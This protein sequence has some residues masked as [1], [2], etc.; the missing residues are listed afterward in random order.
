MNA[1]NPQ[2][3]LEAAHLEAF[4]TEYLE[5]QTRH[6]EVVDR[7]VARPGDP[8]VHELP[9][10]PQLPPPVTIQDAVDALRRVAH[11][12]QQIARVQADADALIAPLQAQIDQIRAWAQHQIT[13]RERRLGIHENRLVLYYRLNSPA[14]GKTLALPGGKI[15]CRA[16]QPEWRYEDERALVELLDA[17]GHP[18][19]RV[20]REV[21]KVKLKAMVEVRQDGT[22][23]DTS[24]GA[25]L[26]GVRVVERPPV[27]KVEVAG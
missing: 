23:V 21:D 9:P 27:Y 4:E 7:L 17:D 2:T 19:I 10:A 12:R 5:A 8:E 6:D 11:H 25:I 22:V 14:G 3:V 15:S 18:A 20:R 1:P 13:D 24:T 26:P 16:Q